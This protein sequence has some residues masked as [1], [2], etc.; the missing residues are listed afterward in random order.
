MN[1]WLLMFDLSF[2]NILPILKNDPF[3]NKNHSM[4]IYIDFLDNLKYI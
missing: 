3:A 1:L 4:K 2:L